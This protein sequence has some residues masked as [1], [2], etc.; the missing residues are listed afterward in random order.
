M[1]GTSGVTQVRSAGSAF[2]LGIVQNG[3]IVLLMGPN[4]SP[5][6][7]AVTSPTDFRL[8]TSMASSGTI[9][10]SASTTVMA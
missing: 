3:V 5:Y 4:R 6:L 1:D 10:T 9:P 7:L 2:I 8:E